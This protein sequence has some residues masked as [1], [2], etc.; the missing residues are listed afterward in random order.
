MAKLEYY[1]FLCIRFIP[2]Q[3]IG[4]VILWE[5][6]WW[7]KKIETSYS[8]ST[9]KYISF[10]WIGLRRKFFWPVSF[11]FLFPVCVIWRLCTWKNYWIK[12]I[13]TIV[14]E[15]S[16]RITHSIYIWVLFLQVSGVVGL[17]FSFWLRLCLKLLYRP[18]AGRSDLT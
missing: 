8:F 12:Q 1:Y 4:E 6:S 5:N 7:Y 3:I 17:L 14:L 2:F 11:L 13:L 15:T 18:E 10:R 9:R 16:T